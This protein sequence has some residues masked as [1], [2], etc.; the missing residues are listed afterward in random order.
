MQ[1]VH[2]DSYGLLK[3]TDFGIRRCLLPLLAVKNA[4][5]DDF[6]RR[7]VVRRFIRVVITRATNVFNDALV[8]AMQPLKFFGIS[9][10][11]VRRLTCGASA[12]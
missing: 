5:D 9:V 2:I 8:L 7:N 3:L 12:C 11:G 10:S 6:A 1:A 4:V